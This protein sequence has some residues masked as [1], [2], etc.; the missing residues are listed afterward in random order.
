[1]L[2]FADAGE[3]HHEKHQHD[4]CWRYAS[5][6]FLAFDNDFHEHHVWPELGIDRLLV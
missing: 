1:M 3:A 4:S 5:F 6:V 2:C